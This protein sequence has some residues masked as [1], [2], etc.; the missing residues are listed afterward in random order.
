MIEKIEIQYFRS[1]YKV[2]IDNIG[3]INIFTG[4]NDVGKSNILKALNLFFN[5]CISEIGDYNF[6][7]NY[8]LKRLEEVRK[9][10]VKGKQFIQI[11]ITFRRGK[12]YEKT[13][14]EKFIVS[15]K[16]NRDSDIPQVSDNIEMLLKKNKKTYNDR[17]KASLTRYLN[18]LKYI[19]IPAIKDKLIFEDMIKRLQ[20]TVY[21]RK[22]V[23]NYELSDTMDSL[24]QNV[25]NTTRELSDEFKK[26]TNIVSMIA[27]PTE[28]DQ[29]YKTL[30]IIT[31][32]ENS[33]VGLEDRGD[34]IRVR[35]IPSILN[36]ISLNASENYIWGF[37]EP[38]NSLEFNLARK[39]ANDFYSI[40]KKNSL[41][42]VTTHSPAF[43]DIGYMD[44]GRGYRCYKEDNVTE[45]VD[46][47]NADKLT[48]LEEELGYAYILKKQFDEYKEMTIRNEE[49]R[50]TVENLQAELK[51]SQKPVLLTE[52]KT[53]AKIL[54]IAWEKLYGMECPFDI[55]SCNLLEEDSN[56]NAVAGASVLK[57]ILC[58]TRF[59]S[60]KIVIGLFDNDKAGLE[61]FKLDANYLYAD[62]KLWKEH[63]NKKGYA[64]VIPTNEVL[65]EIA[66]IKNLS[67]EFLFDEECL[68]KE[69]NGKKLNFLPS[70][71]VH[72]INGIT[73]SS[74]VASDKY[75]YYSKIEDTTKTQFAF[76]VV[77]TFEKEKFE[78][79]RLI[80]SVVLDILET[81]E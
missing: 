64:F 68:K 57:K 13:L 37:E 60:N 77:P 47:H 31:K 56:D 45:I 36:Y 58:S 44:E 1:I 16:W 80:F 74:E 66:K 59:D 33:T 24:Y 49:M 8:N 81:L 11:K 19:Y 38:E 42:F 61:E 26:A 22:L 63:K 50:L 3:S 7:Q 6:M 75:W 43:I 34:G 10:T 27:T 72:I 41:I 51:I 17:N 18:G 4:K 79:F 73:V 65:E 20:N 30:K 70:K 67:I 52:G 53:D 29:L 71:S 78:N 35:Y 12:Q 55:K 62:N 48:A 76:D 69:V 15:K 28:V 5:N 25:V 54:N 23:G 14:P 21:N 40:Y 32:V 39:M 9:D 2:S 46:F